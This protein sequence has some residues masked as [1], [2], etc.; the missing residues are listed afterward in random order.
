MNRQGNLDRKN[1]K[2]YQ[3]RGLTVEFPYDAYPCQL[4]YMGKVIETLQTERQFALLESPTGTGKTLCLLCAS[5]AWLTDEKAKRRQLREQPRQPS[6]DNMTG[7]LDERIKIAPLPRLV[8]A[9]RTHS[10]LNQVRC[11]DLIFIFFSSLDSY[12]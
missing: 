7:G 5:L 10:Q 4:D 3:I 1:L 6:I 2:F 8:Y 9:S 11:D 12:A